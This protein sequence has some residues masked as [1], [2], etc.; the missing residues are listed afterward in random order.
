MADEEPKGTHDDGAV[1]LTGDYSGW[2]WRKIKSAITGGAD[3]DDAQYDLTLSDPQT[4]QDAANA[5]YYTQKV[6]ED[7]AKS[8][9]EQSDALAGEE[10]PWQGQAAHAFKATMGSFA[11]QVTAMANVL[12]GGATGH[13]NVPQQL[14]NNAQ[15]LREA[16][17]KVGDIDV[18]Y[19]NEAIK[20]D[21]SLK[22]DNGLVMVSKA[23]KIPQMMADDMR[24]VLLA[25][26]KHYTL[27]ADAVVQ[28]APPSDPTSGSPSDGTPQQDAGDATKQ[29]RMPMETGQRVWAGDATKQG[30]MPMETGQ[31]VWAGDATKQGRMPMET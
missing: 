21:P 17:A 6:L 14:A 9:S 11:D 7:V 2:D 18:W 23:D 13:H 3:G 4:V 15:H 24:Q 31:R 1:D 19:A 29:G 8:L 26:A 12:S 10:R 5:F 27:T 30:R 25:L 16:I 28:P 22:M 20:V